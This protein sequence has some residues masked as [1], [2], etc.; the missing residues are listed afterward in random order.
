MSAVVGLSCAVG[1]AVFNGSFAVLFKTEKMARLNVHPM[2]FQ[3]YV[4]LGIFVSSLFTV[5]CGV[6]FEFLEF[7]GWGLVAGGLFVGAASASFFAVAEIGVALGQGIWGGVAMVVSYFWGLLVFGETP[8]REGLSLLG[9]LLLVL[10]VCGVAFCD[11]IARHWK[12]QHYERLPLSKQEGGKP[13]SPT[14]VTI[15]T[16]TTQS[17]GRGV[18]WAIAVGAFGGSILAPMHYVPEEKQGLVFLPSFGLGC[19]LVSPSVFGL[20]CLMG[21][22]TP[23]LHIREAL[24]TGSLSGLIWNVGNLLSILAIPIVSYGV[25]YPIMQCAILVSGMWGIYVFDEI[26]NASTI[27]VFWIG[28]A[29][30]VIGGFLLAV[31]Q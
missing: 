25:A 24:V 10:G 16:R 22:P 8:S 29:T 11:T 13:P 5:F 20:Y 18:L 1:S 2:T 28:G 31:S 19:L 6:D 4:C 9:L 26:T 21:G 27:Q 3:L 12:G 7:T 17:Y 15:S 23:K 14:E 30:L